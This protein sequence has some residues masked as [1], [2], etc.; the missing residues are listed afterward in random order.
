MQAVEFVS[1]PHDNLVQ[2]PP[3][4]CGWNDRPVRVILMAEEKHHDAEINFKAVSL[5]TRGY[6]F[7]REDANAR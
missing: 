6:R 7:D 3:E 5:S 2:L 1:T 4:L